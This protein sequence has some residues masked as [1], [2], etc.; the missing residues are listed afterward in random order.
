MTGQIEKVDMH[1]SIVLPLVKSLGS[2]INIIDK[3]AEYAVEKKIDDA[4]I[5]NSR[6][7]F[8]M[9]PFVAQI[10]IATDNAKGGGA[11][12]SGVEIPKF[13]DNEKTLEELKA[14]VQ[15]TIDFLNSLDAKSFENT[16]TKDIVL[17]FGPNSYPFKGINYVFNFVL[18]NVYF[19]ISIA[20]AIL[21]QNGVPLG[22]R[23]YLG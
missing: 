22:K 8:D 1:N 12:L 14:R 23:D 15:K 16:E 10:Q 17:T 19:H 5:L 3:A 4:T 13:E 21:R 11:R 9:L 2:L 18:P 7:T 20:Y 6:L